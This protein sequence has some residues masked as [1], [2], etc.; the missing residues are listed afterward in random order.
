MVV[1]EGMVHR[2][3][4]MERIANAVARG[5][6]SLTMVNQGASQIS[7]MVGTRRADADKAVACIY[8]EFFDQEGA[9]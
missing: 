9:D 8:N 1:G 2:V 4:T 5:G 7:I 6:M 3:G